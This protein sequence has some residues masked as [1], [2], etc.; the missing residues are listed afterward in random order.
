MQRTAIVAGCLIVVLLPSGAAGAEREGTTMPLKLLP[1]PQ[2]VAVHDEAMPLGAPQLAGDGRPS[3]TEELAY[4]CV[5]RA[6]E[7]LLGPHIEEGPL[8]TIVRIGSVEEGYVPEWLA[9]DDR[10]FLATPGTSDEAYVLTVDCGGVCIVGKGRWGAVYG[11]QTLVQL[12]RQAR[13]DGRDSLPCLHVRDWPAMP[14]RCLSPSLTWY[15]GWNRLEGYD[16]NNW[17]L[18][19]WKWLVDWSLEHKINCWAVCMYGYWPFTLPGYEEATLDLDSDRF[20]PVRGERVTRR[21]THR[22]IQKEFWPELARYAHERGV[23][24]YAYIGKNSFNGGYLL[25]HP[26][27]NAGG[28]AEMLPFAPGVAEYWDAFTGR[29]LESGFDGFVFE[30]PEANNV[31]NQNEECYRTFW[32]PWAERYG[33]HSRE[34]TKATEPPLGVHIEYYTWLFRQFDAAIQRHAVPGRPAP[35]VYL[36]SHMLLSRILS[37]S[38]NDEEALAW[39]R[40][41]DEK[42]GHAV[43]YVVAEWG[44]ERYVKLLGGDRVASLGG[45]GGSCICAWRRMTGVNSNAVGG[46]M[47]AGVDW[48][49][50]CQRRIAAAGGFGAMAYVF[51]WR[52]NEIYGY[53]GAQHLWRPEGVP[54]INNDDQVGFLDYA[55]RIH[56]GDEVGALVARALDIS[57]CVNDAMVLEGV[58]GAQYPETGKA[59]H[60]DYQLLAAQAQEAVR[61]AREAYRRWAGHEP[62]LARAAY[63]AGS[64]RWDGHSDKADHAFKEES[65]RWLCVELERARFLCECALAHRRAASLAAEEAPRRAV[66]ASLD[67]AIAAASANQRLYQ[68]NFDDD[69]HWNEGL[70]VTL[71]ERLAELRR[72]LETSSGEEL[73]APVPAE[74]RAALGSAPFLPWRPMVDRCPERQVE[75]AAGLYLSVDLAL[76]EV[77]DP[78][79]L[80][81]VFTVEMHDSHGRRTLFRRALDR[82]S[83]GWEHWDIPLDRPLKLG[84]GARLRLVTDAYSRS[85]SREALTWRWALWGEPRVVRIRDDGRREILSDLTERAANGRASIRLDSELEERPLDAAASQ[86]TGAEFAP[87]REGPVAA[88]IANAR[89]RQ[90][91]DGY[92]PRVPARASHSGP[93]RNYLGTAPSYW[94]YARESGEVI[95][96]T[97]PI[98]EARGTN[99]VFIGGTDYTPGTAELLC[100]GVSILHFATG[101]R[102]GAAWSEDDVTLRYLHGGD[103]RDERTTFGL[104]GTFVL[105]LPGRLVTAGEPLELAVRMLTEGQ[106]WF[107]LHGYEHPMRAGDSVILPAPARSGFLAVPPHRDGGHGIVA[108]EWPVGSTV[109]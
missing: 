30:D 10:A 31:P 16:L 42:Q 40:L 59:L 5:W 70:C 94:G 34:E 69:Y 29:I 99:L 87:V 77:R 55:Y 95:W 33:F 82:R 54:G 2:E 62:D 109:P 47:G 65:L 83:E 61:L 1:Y 11:V 72:G 102:E 8:W 64:F 84:G 97:A 51:E 75:P 103:I 18:D 60:R 41:A 101:S 105:E 86:G 19:E 85:Q 57:P 26:E 24:V 43:K 53:I 66:I 108:M 89:D 15:S 38:A 21:F 106:S 32:E 67:R 45:R 73:A 90:W 96:R 12:I 63:E 88:L 46:P 22:N 104:S 39:L 68:V 93:Y 14:W 44:E 36:I 78:S 49:R 56:Y 13:E 23:R 107:M 48:E 28:A 71:G 100:N 58:H 7:A 3:P 35:E 4:E 80:G 79:C 81:A 91:V 17:T 98:P 25:H 27:T 20:D 50:D 52:S 74:Q 9:A 6:S 92:I 37:E 76:S